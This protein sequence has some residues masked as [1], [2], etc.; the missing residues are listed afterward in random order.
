MGEGRLGYDKF[1]TKDGAVE[2]TVCM[3]KFHQ[4]IYE[5]LVS[6]ALQ[7]AWGKH[8]LYLVQIPPL[9]LIEFNRHI[10]ERFGLASRIRE[11]A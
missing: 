9:H 8:R 2:R 4:R 3:V 1:M 11:V 7:Q 6:R 10:R 5:F